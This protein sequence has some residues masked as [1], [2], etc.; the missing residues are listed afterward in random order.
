VYYSTAAVQA[1]RCRRSAR[2]WSG[3]LFHRFPNIA[4]GRAGRQSKLDNR[5]YDLIGHRNFRG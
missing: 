2:H 4:I 5:R 1:A 3:C